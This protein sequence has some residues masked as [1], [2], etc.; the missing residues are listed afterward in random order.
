MRPCDTCTLTTI[1]TTG[2]NSQDKRGR[3]VLGF[4]FIA[5]H[6]CTLHDTLLSVNTL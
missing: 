1:T 3:E 5:P 6:V 4:S 2:T